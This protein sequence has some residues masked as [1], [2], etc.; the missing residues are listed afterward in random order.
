M[1]QPDL[2]PLKGPAQAAAARERSSVDAESFRLM[3]EAV[4]DYAILMLDPDGRVESWNAGAERIKGYAAGEIVGEHFTRFYT[5]EDREAGLPERLLAAAREDGRVDDEGWRLRKDGSR[6]WASVV[7]TAMRDQAGELRGYG[8]VTRDL[9][10]RHE[11]EQRLRASEE[12]F[13]AAFAHAPV[14]VALVGLRGKD[15]GRLIQTNAALGRIVGRAEGDLDD[16]M[17]M[18]LEHPDG[19]RVTRELLERVDSGHSI[20]LEMRFVHRAGREIWV[21]VSSTPIPVPDG[22]PEYCVTQVLDVSDRKRFEGQLRY[23][24]DHDALTGLYNRHRFESELARVV[25]ETQRYGRQNALLTLDLDG[26]KFVNDRLGHAVGDQLVQRIAGLLRDTVRSTD[27]VARLGGDEFAIIL[28]EAGEED[29]IAISEKILES[30]RHR[31]VVSR[32]TGLAKVTTSIGIT[33]F[34]ADCTLNAEELVIEADVAM[35]D[36]KESGR[37]RFSVYD[38]ATNRRE[39]VSKRHSWLERIRSAIDEDRFVL[40]AQPIKGIC[41]NGIARYELLLRMPDDHGDLIP[42]GAFLY[43]AERFDLMGDIDRWV[44]AHAIGLL[45]EH[46]R[47]GNQISL[48]V[49]LSGKSMNDPQLAGD[50]EAMLAKHPV[51]ADRL[52]IE[53]TETAAIVNIE[54]ARELAAELRALG[55]A[56]AL[57]DF[58]AGFASFYYLKHLD[59]DYLKI[60]GE[61]IENLL[62][63]ASDQLV[64][65]AVVEIARGLGTQTIAEFVGSDAA[66]EL[67]RELGV[68]YGQG[69]HLGRPGP[70]EL[71][72]PKLPS[73][74]V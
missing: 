72:L 64:V 74:V 61:F 18:N 2:Q 52:I 24:A 47:A 48:N 20:R 27:I 34:D 40:H 8:K 39:V 36:A 11:A 17:L 63:T 65:K 51:P 58:G 35:Y 21:L 5:P 3:V 23:L 69:Y 62:D 32:K 49:N 22:E 13:H 68:D 66:V 14:G 12:R 26:F 45:H 28:Q 43:N 33:I 19:R 9:T 46:T 41:A 30:V 37:D 29:A 6:F 60:D 55:C 44:L 53:V 50:L 4:R 59:F 1:R 57:D 31:A 71:I 42:P 7:I 54:R 67:L 70:L 10:E 16:T 15:R 25:A 56:F 73:T 38:R